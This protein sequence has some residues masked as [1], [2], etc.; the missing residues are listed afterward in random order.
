MIEA[1]ITE[2]NRVYRLWV[3]N[4]PDFHEGGGRVHLIA[5]SLGSAMA[6]EVLSKQPTGI[7]KVDPSGEINR[8]H[9]DF[10]TTNLFFAGS[11]AGFFLLLDKVS[12]V[13]S[14]SVFSHPLYSILTLACRQ[15]SFH[16]EA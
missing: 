7:P 1:V 4:N 16:A 6:M 12:E 10:K 14:K 8:D 2:A 3:R 13:V 5:H 9:F 11:P 15:T